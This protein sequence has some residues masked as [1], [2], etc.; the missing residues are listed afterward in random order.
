MSLGCGLDLQ[1]GF[2]EAGRLDVRVRQALPEIEITLRQFAV[3]NLVADVGM[4]ED[5]ACGD[6]GGSGPYRNRLVLVDENDEFIVPNSTARFLR[7]A[8]ILDLGLSDHRLVVGL[9]GLRFVPD[10]DIGFRVGAS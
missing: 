4:P 9:V 5:A 1:I 10:I 7:R 2:L 6:I 8:N 3:P